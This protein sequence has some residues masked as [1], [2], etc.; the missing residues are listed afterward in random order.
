MNWHERHKENKSGVVIAPQ[1]IKIMENIIELLDNRFEVGIC[2][3]YGEEG[4]ELPEGKKAILFGDWND[5][6]KYPNIME[7]LEENYE[8]EWYDEWYVC[9]NTG[10]AY[11]T[12]P[13][14][15]SWESQIMYS[16]NI[17]R[18]LTP[19]D[20]ISDWIDEVKITD[21]NEIIKALPSF[22]CEDEIEKEGF[23]LI[24]ENFENGHYGKVDNP[25]DIAEK[26]FE[27]GFTEIVFQLDYVS[28]FSTGFIAY[29][30]K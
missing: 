20:D 13:N 6:D 9:Y 2:S 14:G 28:Q 1:K 16:E 11:R 18:Y 29:A 5:L 17:C 23:K 3:E 8:L 15:Y 10:K 12:Q 7:Y 26:L 19:D 4:Y 24:E 25:K 22:I 21:S 27:E 30:K